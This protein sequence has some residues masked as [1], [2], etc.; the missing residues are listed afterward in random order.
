MNSFRNMFAKAALR[1]TFAL[2]LGVTAV[3]AAQSTSTNFVDPASGADPLV[4]LKPGHPRLLVS[5]ADWQ[6][7]RERQ[8]SDPELAQVIAR[9]EADAKSLL[10]DP[11]LPYQKEGKRLLDISRQAVERILLWSVT[12]HLTGDRI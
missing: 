10:G 7:L 9:I 12:Y 5:D 11:P 2:A 8:K 4:G 6:T 1:I 3:C